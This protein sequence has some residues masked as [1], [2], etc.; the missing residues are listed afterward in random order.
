MVLY[1]KSTIKENVEHIKG[2]WDETKEWKY[3]PKGYFLIKIDKEKKLIEVGYC[4]GNNHVNRCKSD[5]IPES[6][7]GIFIF[8]HCQ[9]VDVITQNQKNHM[10]PPH[11]SNNEKQP[12]PEC[13]FFCQ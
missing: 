12:L 5:H 9:L 13:P 2:I 4:K 3:D 6:S 11:G 8:F 10:K 7:M 1:P